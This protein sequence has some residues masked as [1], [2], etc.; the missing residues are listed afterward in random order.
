LFFYFQV[1]YVLNDYNI[2]MG[3]IMNIDSIFFFL[4]KKKL[5][6]NKN[7]NKKKIYIKNKKIIKE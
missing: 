7:K 2:Q 1:K 5:C 3:K 4:K 6:L